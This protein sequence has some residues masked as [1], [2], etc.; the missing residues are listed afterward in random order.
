M[1]NQ[2][3]RP[4]K[5]GFFIGL[6]DGWKDGQ[7]TR[8]TDIHAM[9]KMVEEVGFDSLWLPDHLL[10]QT[11]DES[12]GVWECT[13]ILSALAATTT[14]VELGTL[15]ACNTFRNPALLAKMADTIDEIS[16]GRFT[17]GIGAGHMDPEYHAF[18]YPVDH[19]YSRFEEAIQIIHGLLREG[20]IDFEGTFYQAR[21]CE[22]LPRGPRPMGPPI[23]IGT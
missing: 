7:T 22:L 21:D 5:I 20:C 11:A 16:G 15:V 19:R 3:Q 4:L 2:R 18:G 8:W 10:V 6:F 12:V 23:M 1:I 13:S 9:A 14:R 17:L